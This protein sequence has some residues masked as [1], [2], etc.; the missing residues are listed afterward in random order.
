MQVLP[1]IFFREGGLSFFHCS[2]VQ[3]LP[4]LQVQTEPQV[5]PPDTLWTPC[6][7]PLVSSTKTSWGAQNVPDLEVQGSQKWLL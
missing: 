2:A 3:V 6:M 1:G 4:D 5:C 7:C